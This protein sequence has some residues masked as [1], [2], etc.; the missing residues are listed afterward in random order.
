MTNL[1]HYTCMHGHAAIGDRGELLPLR[2]L[3]PERAKM[4]RHP[5]AP[6]T[7][8]IWLTDLDT[9]LRTQLGLT[10]SMLTCDRTRH[11][12]RVTDTT[13]VVPYTSIR[14]TLPPELV[15][16]LE[17]DGALPL[18]W[19]VAEQPVPVEYDPVRR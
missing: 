3:E 6:L 1:W 19:W 15:A 7:R 16:M 5:Y 12:Y 10:S 2:L 13:G 18:H 11:R 8:L 14:H 17:H 4:L 9:P